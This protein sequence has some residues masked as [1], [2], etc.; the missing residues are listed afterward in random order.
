[1]DLKHLGRSDSLGN[2]A[3]KGQLATGLPIKPDILI[4]SMRNAPPSFQV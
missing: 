4:I 2:M 3:G 1:M